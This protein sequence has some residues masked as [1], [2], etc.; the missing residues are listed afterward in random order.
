MKNEGT[1]CSGSNISPCLESFL[2]KIVR[3][4]CLEELMTGQHE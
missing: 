2:R 3:G 4:H 1:S